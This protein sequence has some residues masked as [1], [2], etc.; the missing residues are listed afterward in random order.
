MTMAKNEV[1]IGLLDDNCYLV[2]GIKIWWGRFFLMG[3][4]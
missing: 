1:F 4:G 2:G 3:Q